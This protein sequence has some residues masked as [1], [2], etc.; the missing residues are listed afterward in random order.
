MKK[1]HAVFRWALLRAHLA[2]DVVNIAK[3]EGVYKHFLCIR[4]HQANQTVS[5]RLV[6]FGRPLPFISQ[7]KWFLDAPYAN[8]SPL[9][10]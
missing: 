3:R 5:D 8:R 9:R 4:L 1:A 7:L 2:P 6:Q 10:P